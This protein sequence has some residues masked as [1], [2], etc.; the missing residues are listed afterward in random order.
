M[1]LARSRY[2]IHC[3][4]GELLRIEHQFRGQKLIMR[5]FR[6]ETS[7]QNTALGPLEDQTYLSA[8]DKV[9]RSVD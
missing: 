3:F 4:P 8:R 5:L 9:D 7:P 2:I 1:V 6:D